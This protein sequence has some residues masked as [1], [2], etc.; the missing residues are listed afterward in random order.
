ML[1]CTLVSDM[2]LANVSKA[3]ENNKEGDSMKKNWLLLVIGS[4]LALMI[5]ACSGGGG[6]SSS[7]SSPDS[8]SES[9]SSNDAEQSVEE[10]SDGE[11]YVIGTSVPSLEFTFFVA[12]QKEWEQ[13]AE[14]QGVEALFFNGEDNQSKQNQDIEDMVTRGVDALVII[15]ITTEGVIP[16]IRYANENGIPVFTVDRSV[17][18]GSGV[19]VV[20]HIGTNHV[21]MGENAARKFLQGLEELHPDVA[22]WKVAELEGTP[23]SSA[24]IERGRGIHNVLEADD[25]VEIVTSLTGEFSS[26]V[27]LD[28]TEDILTAH[29]ELHGIIAHND[30]MIEGALQAAKGAGRA[31][32]LVLYGMDGQVSTVERVLAGEIYGTSLQ[33]PRMLGDGLRTAVKYLNGEEVEENVWVPTEI[34]DRDNAQSMLDEGKAW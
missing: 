12:T 26:T 13:A 8:N 23:G 4:L 15:P 16:A 19:E 3:V 24:A 21:D 22:T 18:E 29:S 14:E 17:A 11:K 32:D 7:S 25:R 9:N 30:M 5:V 33:L 34:I 2:L 31:E 10:S 6:S 1:Y 20:A 28:V 27:A